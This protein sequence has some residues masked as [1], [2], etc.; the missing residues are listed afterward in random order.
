MSVYIPVALRRDVQAQFNHCCAYCHTA[1][2]LTAT[3]YEIEHI[4]PLVDGGETILSNLCYSCPMCNR[5]KGMR[6]TAVTPQT[7]VTITLF[8]PQKEQW[9]THFAWNETCTELIGLTATGR[10][11]I[12][13]LKI[14]R[15]QLVRVRRMWVKLG[16]HPPK[17]YSTK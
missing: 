16:E 10:A 14:N 12:N 4:I 7:N 1:E 6:Q 3:T 11:T 8:H 13:A 15:P 2:Q 5:Y 17:G 9:E